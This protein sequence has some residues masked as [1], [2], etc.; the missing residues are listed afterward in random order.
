VLSFK[1]FLDDL[2]RAIDKLD[3]EADNS[4]SQRPTQTCGVS[5]SCIEYAGHMLKGKISI[6]APQVLT[7]PKNKRSKKC[8]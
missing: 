1:S 8:T 7:G 4:L 6:R 5:Q 2:E 3:L